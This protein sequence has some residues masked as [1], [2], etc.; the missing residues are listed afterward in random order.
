MNLF[1]VKSMLMLNA[2]LMQ[3]LNL[4]SLQDS[5]MPCERLPFQLESLKICLRHAC[6]IVFSL[7]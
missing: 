3:M 5:S 7:W 1:F 2:M 6:S 4:F